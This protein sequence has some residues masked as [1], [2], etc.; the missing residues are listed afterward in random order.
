MQVTVFPSVAT[1]KIS[2]IA[3]KS[4]AHRLLICASFTNKPSTI[5]CEQ[6]ND[7]I[8]ATVKCLS[9]L[10]A[11]ITRNDVFY[12]VTPIKNINKNAILNCNESGSTLRFLLPIC[13]AL[14]GNFT[15]KMQGRLPSRPLSPLKELLEENGI[16]I[17]RP[18][19]DTLAISGKL[20][21]NEFKIA[22][23]VSSQFISGLL[24]ALSIS[25]SKE[26]KTVKITTNIESEPY[27]NLTLDALSTF[28]INIK[29]IENCFSIPENSLLI[30]PKALNVEGDWSNAAF[31]LAL[32][33]IGKGVV[34][35]ENLFSL[36]KQGDKE[37]IEILRAFGGKIEESNN[38][39]TAYPSKLHGIDINAENIPDLV[40]ILATV[41]SVAEGTTV[42]HGAS[43]LRLKES[44]RLTA[45]SSVLSNLGAEIRQTDD[46][47]IIKGKENLCGGCADSFGDHRIAMS[48]AVAATVSTHATTITRADA[49]NK[50]YPDFWR[51]MS[52]LGVKYQENNEK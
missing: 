35:I 8:I 41:A 28:G 16:T 20:S 9:A 51:D 34:S 36:S 37:I 29:K 14:D 40:P 31:P 13:A 30:A 43:R 39:F 17:N 44:D 25:N 27:I 47:L 33:I 6:I 3:S 23:N 12:K 45:I 50:S 4:V 1:G 42:I 21:G 46:G 2:A 5:R 38:C 52:A 7:D 19:E 11:K 48:V 10:G 18:T 24:F 32:G 22:G 26:S 15:F 49:V